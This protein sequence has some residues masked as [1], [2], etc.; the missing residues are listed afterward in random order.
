[1]A[2]AR[3]A[4]GAPRTVKLTVARIDPW[5]ALKLSFLLSVALGIA[6]VVAT[7]ILWQ[8]LNG[9][10]V[11]DDLNGLLRGVG[12]VKSQFDLYDYVGLGKVIS[13]ATLVAVF[14]V[15]TIMALTTLVTVLYNIAGSLVGGLNVTLADE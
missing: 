11:F 8:V 13:F 10:G 3:D 9:M 12:G 15:L 1:M 4:A 5:S 6:L 7:V 14:N 2:P